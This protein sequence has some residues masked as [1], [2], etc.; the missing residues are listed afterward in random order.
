MYELAYSILDVYRAIISR[1][2]TI[3]SV[4]QAQTDRNEWMN[5]QT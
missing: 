3:G 2:G 5:G 1:G 4:L